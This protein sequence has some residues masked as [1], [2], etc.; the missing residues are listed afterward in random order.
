MASDE[1]IDASASNA[2]SKAPRSVPDN[3]DELW[4][5]LMDTIPEIEPEVNEPKNTLATHLRLFLVLRQLSI[6]DYF[7]VIPAHTGPSNS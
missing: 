4:D 2:A 5:A 6:H 7:R 3:I 1:K